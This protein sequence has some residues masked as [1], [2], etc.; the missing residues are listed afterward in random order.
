M[1]YTEVSEDERAGAAVRNLRLPGCHQR[2]AHRCLL[3]PSIETE[4][5]FLSKKN[6]PMTKRSGL[7]ENLR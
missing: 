4:F 1:Q 5:Y 3:K 6:R 2:D 7:A